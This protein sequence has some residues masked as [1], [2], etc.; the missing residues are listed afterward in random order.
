M[1]RT[2]GLICCMAVLT[3]ATAQD[4][5]TCPDSMFQLT[6]RKLVTKGN[7]AYDISNTEGMREAI[8]AISSAIQQRS[9]KGRL[10][11]D[12]SLEFTADMYKLEGSYHYEM[13]F[14]DSRSSAKAHENYRKALEIY[15]NHTDSNDLQCEPMIH[16]E[17]AI[18]YYKEQNYQE[19]YRQMKAAYEAFER[20]AELDVIG[21]DDPDYLNIQTQMAMCQARMGKTKEAIATMDRLIG[22]YPASDMHYGEAV[23]KKAKMLMLQEENG[24]K[25]GRKAALACYKQYFTLKKEDALAHFMAMSTAVR[26]R[27]WMSI[28]PF[29]TDCYRLEDADAGFLYDVTLF[30][31]GLL[32]QLDSAGGGRQNIH[33][34]WQMVQEKLK[35]DACAI[36]FVQYEKYGRQQMG[37]LVLRKT[38]MPVFVKMA[39]PDSVLKYEINNQSV[40]SRLSGTGSENF[41][42]IDR[43][44]EDS[45]GVFRLIWNDNLIAAV[46]DAK[47]VYF[48][49]DGYL[50]RMAIEYMLPKE[51]PDWQMYRLSSTRR[52]LDQPQPIGRSKAL[53]V[54]D[55]DFSRG[56]F[57]DGNNDMMAYKRMVGK[58][59]GPLKS[60]KQEIDTI[61]ACR[62]S[63]SDKML[64]G[65]EATESA[66]RQ[67]C[68]NYQIVHVSSHGRLNT[69][70]VPFGT[71]LKT[72]LTNDAMSES[73]IA[74]AGINSALTDQTFNPSQQYDGILSAKE[75]AGLDMKGVQ[76][77]VLACCET[78]LGQV[79]ADGVY[80][81][82]R[83]LKNAGVK[84]M[85]ISLWEADDATTNELMTDFHKRLKEGETVAQAFRNARLKVMQSVTDDFGSY[86]HLRN[87]F[88][89]IDALE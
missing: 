29:V 76:L 5:A 2:F 51:A 8:D 55:A 79:T 12:D 81:I 9:S 60:S 61:M 78:G 24:G 53:I 85:I 49:P 57:G 68:G 32:L 26:E 23:R 6:M 20:A 3:S 31:K 82:Q 83:G 46:G 4:L 72:S 58:E 17:L 87:V 40:L 21:G 34:T 64:C 13:S 48:A 66:F 28:R 42:A 45:A 22:R 71:D 1:K 41:D 44:Y 38:R 39:R 16:R 89:L 30:A 67:L 54:G 33:A 10:N 80:G 63:P 88:V 27:Y 15:Q 75:I 36:E 73:I 56:D 37:A 50:H 14:Y 7:H 59:F 52:L 65:A 11:I 47:K 62:H 25:A 69:Q 84:A 19:A 86:P 18:L 35:P 70:D 74:L 77:T 43:V